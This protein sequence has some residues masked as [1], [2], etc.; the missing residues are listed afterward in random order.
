M[1]LIKSL[2]G[3]NNHP[4]PT[5]KQP[6]QRTPKD[7]MKTL[8]IQSQAA[9]AN[10]S[11]L[12]IIEAQRNEALAARLSEYQKRL[13]LSDDQLGK[14][15]ASSGTYISRY[16]NF[17][18]GQFKGDLAAFEAAAEQLLIRE[19]LMEGDTSPLSASGYCVAAVH[20][21]LNL[22]AQQAQ[23]GVGHGP[24]GKGK[25]KACQ[26][27]AATHRGCLYVHLWDWTSRKELLI[28]ELA[29]VAGVRRAKTDY[30][31]TAALVR[32]LKGSE[33]LI[34]ID[35]AQEL[36]PAG[37]RFI[38]DLHDATQVPIALIGN[39]EIIRQFEANDQ[40][41]SR[42]GRCV[43]VTGAEN[44]EATIMSLLANYLPIAAHNKGAQAEALAILRKDK[45]GASRAVKMHLKLAAQIIKGAPD[46]QPLEAIKL[47]RTQL[48]HAAA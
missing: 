21:F 38:A 2:I 18:R 26:I 5:T 35:N 16:R 13:N 12:V 37:R 44:N 27:Y 7:I 9:A 15:L 20:S 43:D 34:I 3:H 45:G 14:R 41:A 24:A 10:D 40:H 32:V 1:P 23:L 42:L 6:R 4:F 33:R 29:R 28:S 11:E 17:S 25:T 48:I 36:T 31:L 30:S 47:A 19:E 22:V 46:T 8:Q 39:P